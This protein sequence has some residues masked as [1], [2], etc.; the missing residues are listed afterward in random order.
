MGEEVMEHDAENL[1]V[2]LLYHVEKM[3]ESERRRT[4]DINA[5]NKEATAISLAA[6]KE[7]LAL[8]LA[9][10]SEDRGSNQW[11]VGVVISAAIGLAA[12]LFAVFK[13]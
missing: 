10:K 7:A 2:P 8:A 1:T 12:L 11:I 3:M 9:A 4:D 5:A 13:H 6:N